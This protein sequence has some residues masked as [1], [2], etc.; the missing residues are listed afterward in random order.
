MNSLSSV[1]LYFL[2]DCYLTLGGHNTLF[3]LLLPD[4]TKHT[5][6]I[7]ILYWMEKHVFSQTLVPLDLTMS[8]IIES[9]YLAF[10]THYNANL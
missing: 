1:Y 5:G 4:P 2:K 9:Y 8:K 6:C 7:N 3:E 10:Y